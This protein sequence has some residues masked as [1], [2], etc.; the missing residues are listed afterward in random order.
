MTVPGMKLTNPPRSRN[1]KYPISA[2]PPQIAARY[3]AFLFPFQTKNAD[4]KVTMP[5]QKRLNPCCPIIAP[6]ASG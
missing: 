3:M 5:I 6:A 4:I 1:K 2:K